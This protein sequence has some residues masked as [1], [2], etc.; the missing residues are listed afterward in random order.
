M[1]GFVSFLYNVFQLIFAKYSPERLNLD[2]VKS[3]SSSHLFSHSTWSDV[4]SSNLLFVLPRARTSRA[5]RFGRRKWMMSSGG[6]L[7]RNGTGMSSDV[8]KAGLQR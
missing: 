3:K 4:S 1:I 8:A 6:V 5:A 2:L 7:A